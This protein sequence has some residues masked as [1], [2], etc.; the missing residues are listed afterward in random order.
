MSA[1]DALRHEDR[2]VRPD[3]RFATHLRNRLTDALVAPVTLPE[4]TRTMTDSTESAAVTTTTTTTGALHPYITV[5]DAVGA[6]DWYT[7]VFDA[8]ETMRYV[9][10]DGRIGHG[11]L[12]I[13]GAKLMLSDEYPDFGAV[14]PATVGGTPV[15]LYVE[16]PDVDDV[17]DRALSN[18]ADG[19]RPPEDQAYGR[20]ACAFADPFGHQWMVQTVT[21]A[22]STEEIEEGLGGDFGIVAPEPAGGAVDVGYIT[23]P[24]DDTAAARR[25]YGTLF[26]WQADDGDM[27]SDHAHV[28]NT[29]PRVGMTPGGV[30]APSLYF[31]IDDAG[32]YADQVL[33]LGG[34]VLSRSSNPS[35]ATIEC[36][37]DQ[38]SPFTLWQPAEGY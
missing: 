5:G 26:R 32:R 18:G 22:P 11:E 8:R 16:V 29:R 7:A 20:R 10:D 34:R 2:A 15:K 19:Q 33:E 24:F 35:G 12:E 3:A 38:G 23:M 4:R 36:V 1:F 9:G 13:G 21:A 25:F 30:G 27:G 6:I 37:D 28:S 31:R 14:S 17:W